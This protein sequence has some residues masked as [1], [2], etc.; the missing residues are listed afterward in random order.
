MHRRY[1]GR[2]VELNAFTSDQF[3]AWLEGKLQSHQVRKVIPDDATL[4]EAFRRSIALHELDQ[5]IKQAL[6]EAERTAQA[7]TVPEDL[8]VRIAQ[9]LAEHPAASWDD[10]LDDLIRKGNHDV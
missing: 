6:P 8:R 3:V 10:A 7:T 5:R 1:R 2:R 9:M 4:V